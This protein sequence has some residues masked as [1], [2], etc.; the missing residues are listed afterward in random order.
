MT[1]NTPNFIL[2]PS[3]PFCAARWRAV[4]ACRSLLSTSIFLCL[5]SFPASSVHPF[6]AARW[7]AVFLWL[8]PAL[9]SAPLSSSSSTMP[10]RPF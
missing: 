5:S 10:V 1:Q 7:R 9:T 8:F 2:T 6:C 4:F 3:C